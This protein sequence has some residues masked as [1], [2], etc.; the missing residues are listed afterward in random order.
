MTH[1]EYIDPILAAQKC[2]PAELEIVRLRNYQTPMRWTTITQ[3]TGKSRGE[4]KRLHA[5][6]S[7]KTKGGYVP[8]TP[9]EKANEKAKLPSDDEFLDRQGVPFVGT[10]GAIPG[11][12][13][14]GHPRPWEIR[15]N[16]LDRERGR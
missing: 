15:H 10:R 9:E 12:V 2:T 3:I 14:G 5:S 7:R 11:S 13:P 4:A 6:A 1:A 8:Q 16:R